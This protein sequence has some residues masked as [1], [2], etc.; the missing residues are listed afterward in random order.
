MGCPFRE[1]KTIYVTNFSKIK[2]V[3]EEK[4]GVS[5]LYQVIP[6]LNT[7]FRDLLESQSSIFEKS[8][9]VEAVSRAESY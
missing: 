7:F 8:A 9:G 1:T 5:L 4:M 2:C 6:L 3:V